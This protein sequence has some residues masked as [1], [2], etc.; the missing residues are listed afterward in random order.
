MKTG[1]TTLKRVLLV[2]L[3]LILALS[4]AACG[5]NDN[6]EDSESNNEPIKIGTKPMTESRILGEMFKL[7]AEDAGY[8]AEITKDIAGGTTNIMPAMEKGELDMYPEYLS[9]GWFNVLKETDPPG[10]SD[11]LIQKLNE[12][13]NDKYNMKWIGIYGFNNTYAFAV[14]NDFAETNNLKTMSDLAAISDK[15]VFGGN[16]DYMERADGFE[17][18][19]D[20]YGFNFKDVKDIEIGLK[21]EALKSGDID[22]TNAFT[23]DAQLFNAPITALEDDK[24]FFSEYF[25]STVVRQDALTKYPNLEAALEKMNGLINDDEMREL[26][27]AVEVDGKDENTVAREYLVKKE[28][29]KE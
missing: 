5:G 17:A 25:A 8:T 18:V 27:Y 3:A 28:I 1:K 20:E 24:N 10:N 9:T 16:G 2:T 13:Y 14:S 7:L 26:N 22:V 21:Y 11:E 6:N 29:I 19:K 4:M 23:T 12:E 15:A